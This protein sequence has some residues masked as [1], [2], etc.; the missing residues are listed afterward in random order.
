MCRR[1]G[2]E[3]GCAAA[4]VEHAQREALQ[5]VREEVTASEQIAGREDVQMLVDLGDHVVA[6]VTERRRKGLAA[7]AGGQSSPGLAVQQAL[8]DGVDDAAPGCVRV[9]V[10]LR[11]HCAQLRQAAVFALA[12]ISGKPERFVFQDRSAGGTAKLMVAKGVFRLRVGV[13]KVARCQ[14]AIAE[15][16]KKTAVH[17]VVAALGH[18]VD[19]GA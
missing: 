18:D 15:V 9:D 14:P 6:V 17:R 3:A 7:S 10:G 5:P 1:R 2:V 19:G 4:G 8:D 13:E 12:L 16:L 11:G